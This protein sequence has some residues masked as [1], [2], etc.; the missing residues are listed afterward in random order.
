M[1]N[2][3]T[4]RK[5]IDN[6]RWVMYIPSRQLGK[7]KSWNDKW[8]FVVWKCDNNW[9]Q[10]YNYTGCATDPKELRFANQN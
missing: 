8:I 5:P 2:I 3:A 6:G 9:K 7:I 4:L 10:Y 1:I